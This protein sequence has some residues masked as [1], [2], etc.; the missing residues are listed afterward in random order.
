[1]RN[2]YENINDF[3]GNNPFNPQGPPQGN[4]NMGSNDF[5]SYMK[6]KGNS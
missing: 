2:H 1:M 3:N 4:N 6:N 5:D